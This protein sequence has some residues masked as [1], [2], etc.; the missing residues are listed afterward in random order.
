MINFFG[1]KECTRVEYNAE[2]SQSVYLTNWYLKFNKDYQKKME[3]RPK[4]PNRDERGPRDPNRGPNEREPFER[5]P[6][7]PFNDNDI[8]INRKDL[9]R[10]IFLNDIT[11]DEIR[12][13]I[14]SINIYYDELSYTYISEKPV[15]YS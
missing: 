2:I 9:M 15:N 10:T 6:K 5:R 8:R 13:D 11:I 1:V 12:R 14:A 7:P 3:T 4:P